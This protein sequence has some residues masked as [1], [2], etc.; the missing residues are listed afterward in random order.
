MFFVDAPGQTPGSSHRSL[1]YS[2]SDLVRAAECPWATVHILEEKLGRLPRF[3]APEDAMLERTSRLGDQ[4]E[5]AVLQDMIAQCGRFD[6]STGRGV[7]EVEPAGTLDRGALLR[8]HQESI[9]ALRVGADVVF[10]ASFFDGRFHGRSDFLVRE[11]DGRY[12]VFDTKLARHA[13]VTAL[14][15]L[16]AYADQLA[17]AGIPVSDTVTLI[18]GNRERA[19]FSVGEFMA[20]YQERRDRFE[21]LTQ[22]RMNPSAAPLDWWDEAL[23]RCGA[24]PHCLAEIEKHQDVLKVA[25][26]SMTQ[27]KKL[28]Q[29]YDVR[30]MMDLAGLGGRDLPA[31]VR[32]AR[33]Q[34]AMQC[35]LSVPDKTVTY[36]DA[37]GVQQSVSYLVTDSAPL[38]RIPAA[39]PGDIFFDFE[40]DPMWQDPDDSSW[41]IEYLFGLIETPLDSAE[42]PAF[43]PFWAHSREEEKQALLDFLQYVSERR[44]RYPGMKIYH[45]A[46]YEKRALRDLAARHGVGE[47]E[48]DDLLREEVLVDLYESVRASLRISQG[49]YSIKK[50]EPLYMGDQLRMGDVTNAAASVVAYADYCLARDTGE[51]E[52]ANSVLSSISDYN[53]YDCLS[54]LKLRNWLLSLV[55]RSA[56]EEVSRPPQLP[57]TQVESETI[58]SARETPVELSLNHFVETATPESTALSPGELR[59]TVRAVA[60]VSSATGYH[61]RERKQFWWAHFDRLTAPVSDWESQRDVVVFERMSVEEDWHKASPRSK[62]EKRVLAGTARLA[63]GSGLKP[64]DSGL[65][66]MY[67]APL[68]P[69]LENKALEAQQR[70]EARSGG[71][72][73]VVSRASDARLTVESLE[74]ASSPGLV[75]IRM[76]ESRP[77]GTEPFDQIPMASTPSAP[78]RTAAQEDSLAA[79]AEEVDAALPQLP[80]AAG[81][82]ILARRRPRLVGGAALPRANDPGWGDG[83]IPMAD[84]IHAAVSRLDDSY[85]AVQGPPGT[86]KSYVGSHVIGRLVTE[87]WTIG[88]VAQSHAVI[89]NLLRGCITNGGVPAAAIAKAKKARPQGDAISPQVPW[90]EISPKEI[91][92]FLAEAMPPDSGPGEGRVYGGTAWDF[93]NQDRFAPGSLDLLVIDEAGQYS[94][95]NMLAVSRAARNMLLLGDPQQLPQVTQG[96][97]P[98]PVDESALGWLSAGE[99]TLPPEF[100]YFLDSSWRMHPQLCGPVSKLSYQGKLRSAHAAARRVL[101]DT[102][103][104]V[105]RLDV[106]HV[107]NATSSPE[108]AHQVV[109]LA[110]QFIGRSWSDAPDQALRPLEPEDVLVVAAYNAQV[111]VIRDALEKAGLSHPDETGVRVGT[112]DRFQGQEAPIV[113]IS[114]A[115]SSADEVPRGMD[116]LLS[117]NRL[118]VAVSRGQWAAVIVSSPSLTDYWPTNPESLSIL[119]GFTALRRDAA[120]WNELPL[121][122]STRDKEGMI[123]E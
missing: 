22:D 27:R 15:Q 89:E 19:S 75:R 12:A 99:R 119:G 23:P 28:R 121:S 71:Q 80:R 120:R 109:E 111:E 61:R 3:R 36:T 60:M 67:E 13:K 113:I 51:N 57:G 56:T 37:E 74:P 91:S 10:Q 98:Y 93:A 69:Y 65:F 9:A 117:P 31:P 55:S 11:A 26:M 14:L 1:V 86:G 64:G 35:G 115:A 68:P 5:A 8:K 102:R 110:R 83:K 59:D 96:S 101:T 70:I 34:A 88:V 73:P 18:L 63:E 114:M 66:A 46:N 92:S 2:A 49:S 103:P 107:G 53:R 50:L 7:Y 62:V 30:T 78:I 24:C 52:H 100:G 29:R 118:N 48:V 44:Q 39:N 58:E 6:R 90:Q 33:D 82:D 42:E 47:E 81:L 4:H 21:S 40:G 105:Y 38:T 116:F 54:T 94:L 84:A 95:A 45:Y 79:L 41:G 85:I 97:H 106:P 87:G 108:E 43:V 72:Q 25:G 17:Q 20:V 123:H 77:Q 112:V 32:S 122:G 16:A 104:G 76:I